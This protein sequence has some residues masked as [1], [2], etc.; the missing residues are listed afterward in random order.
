[1]AFL[2]PDGLLLG[3]HPYFVLV[4]NPKLLYSPVFVLL[5][6][7]NSQV[8]ERTYAHERFHTCTENHGIASNSLEIGQHQYKG[9]TVKGGI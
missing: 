3:H 6:N 9:G 7:T 1:M 2:S 8:S 4:I 5:F